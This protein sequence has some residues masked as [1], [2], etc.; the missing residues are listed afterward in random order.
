MTDEKIGSLWEHLKTVTLFDKKKFDDGQ[1]I[2]IPNK[3]STLFSPTSLLIESLVEYICTLVE[4]EVPS[5]KKLY[6]TICQ[7][8]HELRLI[9]DSYLIKDFDFIRINYQKELYRLLAVA[10]SVSPT[11]QRYN[12]PIPAVP[13]KN[14]IGKRSKLFEWSRYSSEY[15]ELEF[16]ARGGFGEVV[17][18]QN[19]LDAGIYAIKKICLRYC[20]INRFIRGLSEVQMLAKLNHP[21]IVSYKAAWLEPLITFQKLQKKPSK[22]LRDIENS[23]SKKDNDSSDII[24]LESDQSKNCE[25]S[26]N[27]R[28]SFSSSDSNTGLT[29]DYCINSTNIVLGNNKS[30]SDFETYYFNDRN[31]QSKHECGQEWAILFIQMQLCHQTLRH[32]LDERNMNTNMATN[33]NIQESFNIFKEIVKGVEFIH[34]KGIVHHD[35][36]PNNIFISKDGKEVQV[37]DFGLSCCLLHDACPDTPA[38][39]IFSSPNCPVSVTHQPGEIGTK[40]YAAPEQLNGICDFKSDL[41]SLGIL[42]FELIYPFHTNM[43]R[44]EEINKLRNGVL[45]S[46]LEE[47]FPNTAQ[48]IK[49]LVSRNTNN[50]P[51]GSEL[52]NNLSDINESDED[53]NTTIQKLQQELML[54][55]EEIKQLKKKLLSLQNEI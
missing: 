54:K 50:R 19:K 29:G 44:I 41:F 46:D 21:N 38:M 47:K 31:H 17:K 12:V 1:T 24:F 35:I 8:L 27:N 34:S 39:N 13:M 40:L 49:R 28:D 36:K 18:V 15:H 14:N 16:I 6:F 3:H 4:K 53:K 43:E 45:P 20:S 30:M 23:E 7:K 11:I 51:T 42:L 22:A 37:G 26:S 52:L 9:D 55:N 32:W 25:T 33:V 2:D 10:K 48:L 5:Q